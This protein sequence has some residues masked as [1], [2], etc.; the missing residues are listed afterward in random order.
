MKNYFKIY[1]YKG[2]CI[3]T[4][5][6]DSTNARILHTIQLTSGQFAVSVQDEQGCRILL[7]DNATKVLQQLSDRGGDRKRSRYSYLATRGDDFTVL[8]FC[9]GQIFAVDSTRTFKQQLVSTSIGIHSPSRVCWDA[10]RNLLFVVDNKGH[11]NGGI[12][13]FKV[14]L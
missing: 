13:I 14:D 4:V 10:S 5:R 1:T 2:E 11:Y 3:K 9:N 7:L 8:D 12:W 6:M